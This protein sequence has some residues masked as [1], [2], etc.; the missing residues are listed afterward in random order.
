MIIRLLELWRHELDWV[1]ITTPG[2]VL[3]TSVINLATPNSETYFWHPIAFF[4]NFLIKG[5]NAKLLEWLSKS[6]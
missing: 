5:F 6:N 4:M 2:A 3:Y 1:Q